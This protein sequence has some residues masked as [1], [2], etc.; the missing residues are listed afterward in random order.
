M[1]R[2]L[3]QGVVGPLVARLVKTWSNRTMVEGI[4]APEYENL[5]TDL[6]KL[7][8]R[9]VTNL[10]RLELPALAQA[11]RACG[12]VDPDDPVRAPAIE[13]L[14]RRAVQ[15][16]NGDDLERLAGLLFLLEPGTRD[17]TPAE[18]RRYAAD[19]V[20]IPWET[21]RKTPQER[22]ISQMA[23][24]ILN[25]I[26]DHRMRLARLEQQRRIPA[27]TRL[28]VKWLE[29]FEAYYRIW[30]PVNGLGGDLTAYRSTL[31]G[32]DRLY[33]HIDEDGDEY[34]QEI[35]AT[36]YITFAIY[37]F[38]AYLEHVRR[39][40]VSHGGLWLLSDEPTGQE[41]AD[42][43]YR[44]EWHSPNNE[45]DNSFLRTIY[46]ESGDERHEFLN[47]LADS[48]IGMAIHDD[49]QDWASECQCT[50]EPP[51]EPRPEYFPTHRNHPGIDPKCGLHLMVTACGDFCQLIDE[52]WFRLQDWYS[53]DRKAERG[54]SGDE[55]FK[56]Y[57]PKRPSGNARSLA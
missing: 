54:I 15:D 44:I 7:R 19:E 46:R 23:E 24:M 18:A 30:T 45:R 33:D 6:K 10:R 53:I 9:G 4:A 51:D 17:Y 32:P 2:V 55:L 52:G 13:A 41:V 1:N 34:T 57:P 47:R 39:F 48:K 35:Q 14:V 12:D 22:V 20:G 43:I 31:L 16:L 26:H 29:R 40:G 27:S 3:R 56:R 36:G 5:I 42:A 25:R 21:L 8:E 37:F 28:A 11:V 50:W 49:W 38:A